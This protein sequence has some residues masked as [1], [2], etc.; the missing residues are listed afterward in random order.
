MKNTFFALA[1]LAATT[2]FA[3]S[4]VTISGGIG[5]VL[6]RTPDMSATTHP[7]TG[8]VTP[9]VASRT[10]MN[11]LGVAD[12]A[13][14]FR[15]VEDLGGGLSVSA[16]FNMRIDAT[17]GSQG[18]GQGSRLAQN[19][20]LALAGGF[21]EIASGR[22]NGPVEVMRGF[23]DHWLG[24]DHGVPVFGHPSDA[25]TRYNGML[26]YTT[27]VMAGFKVAAAYAFKES[28]ATA[29]DDTA[30]VALSYASGTLK[31]GLGYTQSSFGIQDKDVITLGAQYDFGVARPA[32]VHSSTENAGVNS[33]RTSLNVTV[34]LGTS[35]LLRA[36]YEHQKTDGFGRVSGLGFGGE[37]YLSK[38]TK[39]LADIMTR[40]SKRA[41]VADWDG[42]GVY[43][44]LKHAF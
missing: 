22:F 17:D 13:L 44:G 25:A 1:A 19:V 12:T 40:D 5:L 24:Y 27:P 42:A 6:A 8:V 20:K 18:P 34:P 23:G 43:M 31:A 30:E 28:T 15:S 35:A 11:N 26:Q 33:K 37:Y 14:T 10:K 21:G 38:R 29:T 41:D 39:L 32:F 16:L 7:T 9:G 2:A 36:G 4:S 3:Q